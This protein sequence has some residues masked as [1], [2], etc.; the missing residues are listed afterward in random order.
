MQLREAAEC[1]ELLEM[2]T[3][4]PAKLGVAAKCAGPA[5]KCGSPVGMETSVAIQLRV[6]AE[7]ASCSEWKPQLQ[8]N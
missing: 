1:A 4:V 7:C 2:E 6:V 5:A 8:R 3:S